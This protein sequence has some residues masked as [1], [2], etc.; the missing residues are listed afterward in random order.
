[1]LYINSWYKRYQAFFADIRSKALEGIFSKT[2]FF[3]FTE[4]VQPQQAAERILDAW[5][6]SREGNRNVD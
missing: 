2:M 5:G 3:E 1:L 4:S 6:K